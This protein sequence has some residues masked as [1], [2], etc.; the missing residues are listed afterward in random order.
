MSV[1]GIGWQGGVSGG[2]GHV[3][4]P[5]HQVFA[6]GLYLLVNRISMNLWYSNAKINCFIMAELTIAAFR[7]QNSLTFL[8]FKKSAIHR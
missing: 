4:I 7:N 6:K 8:S 2:Y 1:V 5:L 3:K